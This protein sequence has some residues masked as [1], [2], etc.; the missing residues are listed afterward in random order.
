MSARWLSAAVALA[1]LRYV[2]SQ[3]IPYPPVV[4]PFCDDISDPMCWGTA[5]DCQFMPFVPTIPQ[6]TGV[7]DLFPYAGMFDGH[8]QNLYS[9]DAE[10]V[11]LQPGEPYQISLNTTDCLLEQ[12]TPCGSIAYFGGTSK[13]ELF[14]RRVTDCSAFISNLDGSDM[15]GVDPVDSSKCF[16]FRETLE[17]ADFPFSSSEI[18]MSPQKD[19]R[20]YFAWINCILMRP[21]PGPGYTAAWGYL[22]EN[23]GKI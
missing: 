8:G 12:D 11:L 19:G 21:G 4:P 17:D 10:N 2:N 9:Y 15:A 20:I 5:G 3:G 7:T 23:Q 16:V 14:F 6:D 13:G 22:N 1:I 18:S